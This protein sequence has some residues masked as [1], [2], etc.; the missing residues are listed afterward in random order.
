[1]NGLP[2][3]D[4]LRTFYYDE[5]NNHRL[6]RITPKGL[7]VPD[8][9]PFVLGGIVHNGDQKSIDMDG[10]KNAIYVQNNG[11]MKF[12]QIAR[13]NFMEILSSRRLK[14][15]LNWIV[16]QEYLIHF[17]VLDPLY[18]SYVD[19]IDSL[20]AV[21]DWEFMPR[22]RV[23][24][25][26]YR[27]LRKDMNGSIALLRQ[28]SYPT[29]AECNVRGF[30]GALDELVLATS[31]LLSVEDQCELRNILR[32]GLDIIKLELLD[33]IPNVIIDG[34][35]SIFIHRICLFKVSQHILDEEKKVMAKLKNIR[36]MDGVNPLNHHRF[37]NSKSEY[38]VQLSDVIVGLLGACF[39]WLKH[40]DD[41]TVH[42]AR[43]GLNTT[44]E[45]NR[46]ALADLVERSITE[47]SLF[48]QY[49]LSLDDIARFQSFLSESPT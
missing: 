24:R 31:G 26:L 18:Y 25:N 47:Q 37:V 10:L 7:N 23:K 43:R 15:F 20:P 16:Q 5:T 38:G 41:N 3:T 32:S 49:L 11:E 36:F 9:R 4:K 19:I 48:V 6:V 35:E 22:M 33:N 2:Y 40:L 46:R 34:F 28:Y 45:E 21:D 30:L 44:Q 13:G 1:M 8:P 17:V 29:V 12:G 14:N 27:V 39:S 42:A